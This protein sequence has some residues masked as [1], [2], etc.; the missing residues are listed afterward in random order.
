VTGEVYSVGA[1]RVARF[2]IGM[3]E[4]YFNPKLT[5]EDVQEHFA[6]IRD[7]AGYTIPAGPADE[8]RAFA[9]WLEAN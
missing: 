2:F 8:F 7:D 6:E 3:T 5:V 4:G 9:K 1:G